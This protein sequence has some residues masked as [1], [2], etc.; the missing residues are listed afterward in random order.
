MSIE[1]LAPEGFVVR[2][3][4]VANDEPPCVRC[5][6]GWPGTKSSNE[7]LTQAVTNGGIKA[8]KLGCGVLVE[9]VTQAQ[10]ALVN[11]RIE[12]GVSI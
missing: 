3:C 5:G 2:G 8:E 6:G 4:P 7:K 1:N 11:F 12:E 10:L 9:R